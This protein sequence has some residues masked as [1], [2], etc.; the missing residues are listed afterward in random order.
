LGYVPID[1]KEEALIMPLSLR[2]NITIANLDSYSRGP[3]LNETKEREN[4][5]SWR[6]LLQI[7]TPSIE[8][9]ISSLSGGNQQ[10]AVV[11]RWLDANAKILIMNEPTRG[12]DVGAK[13]E[14]YSLMN[15]LCKQGTGIVMFSSEMPELLAIAD[16]ILVM[17]A[18]RITGE[19]SHGEATQ[20][21]LMNCAVA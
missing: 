21:D 10:K 2:K 17:S 11:G 13:V 5:N 3:F 16:R 1:R 20:E 9:N 6:T 4:A 15:E 12:I 14:M 18:G 19:F 7:R 8:T